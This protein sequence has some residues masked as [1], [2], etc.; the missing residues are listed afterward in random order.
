[1]RGRN[2][3]QPMN[4]ESADNYEIPGAIM[5]TKNECPCSKVPGRGIRGE[6]I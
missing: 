1:V 3:A 6:K 5:A 4:R 2:E